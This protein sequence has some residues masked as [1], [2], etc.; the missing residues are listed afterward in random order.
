M[1]DEVFCPMCKRELTG[2]LIVTESVVDKFVYT[3]QDETAD[4]NWRQ[5]QGCLSILCKACDDAQR[6]YCCE[7]GFILARERATAAL[8][9]EPEKHALWQ[10]NPA[11]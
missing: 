10:S 3:V 9:A 4:C 6:Y 7:E 11:L 5:C 8:K 1:A 2:V